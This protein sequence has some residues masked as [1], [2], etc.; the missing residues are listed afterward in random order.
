MRRALA[1]NILSLKNGW[2]LCGFL[3]VTFLAGCTATASGPIPY[4]IPPDETMR[5]DLRV[6]GGNA[7]LAEGSSLTGSVYMTNGS[8]RLAP[9]AQI[10][11]DIVML[12]GKLLL[13]PKAV[14]HGDIILFSGK[15]SIAPDAVI[16]GE[17][18]SSPTRFIQEVIAR[19][20]Q[21]ILL[22]CCLPCLILAGVVG[23]ILIWRRRKFSP[24]AQRVSTIQIVTESVPPVEKKP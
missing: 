19:L 22:F 13:Q 5:G 4:T 2:W 23:A 10:Q 7:T 3:V 16:S 8:L 1:A 9:G 18:T 12:S 14:V 11:E 20:L 15:I 6:F 24:S 17:L 21:Q